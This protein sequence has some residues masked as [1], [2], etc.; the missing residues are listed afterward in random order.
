MLIRISELLSPRRWNLIRNTQKELLLLSLSVWG[1]LCCLVFRPVGR[2][3]LGTM[4]GP[5]ELGS[6]RVRSSADDSDFP[7]GDRCRDARRCAEA[8]GRSCA[9]SRLTVTEQTVVVTHFLHTFFVLPLPRGN[10]NPPTATVDR[11]LSRVELWDVPQED[12]VPAPA[13]AV[14]A[15]GSK[16]SRKP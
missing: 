7:F 9:L 5:A 15:R 6:A 3:H 13:T 11:F 8:L 16:R 2:S 12:P 1:P 10:W 4:A 14:R